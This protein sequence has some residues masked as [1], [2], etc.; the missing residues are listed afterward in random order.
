MP[1][2]AQIPARYRSELGLVTPDKTVPQLDHFA[3]NGGTIIAVGNATQLVT[4][5][6]TP[7]Q[8]AL[9]KTVDGKLAPLDSKEFYIPGA[10]VEAKVDPR[11]PLAYGVPATVNVFFN[12]SQSFTLTGKGA[13]DRVSWYDSEAP[14]RSGWALGQEKLKG[15]TAIA[16]VSLGKGKLF[17][18]GPEVTQRAQPYPTFKF[19][20]NG[21]LYGPAQS[22]N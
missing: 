18:M 22:K 2:P 5:L 20:F 15:T 16:D 1:E 13:V 4:M 12:Q 11:E 7:L 3:R 6:D 19:L 9:A 21:I 8:P 14:L 10:I 17:V